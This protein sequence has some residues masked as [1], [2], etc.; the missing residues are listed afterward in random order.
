MKSMKP[1]QFKIATED[2]EL[3]LI[4]RLNYKTFVEEIPQH[5]ANPEG[6]L[7]DRFHEQ[8]TYVIALNDRQL[9]GMVCVRDQRPFSLDGKLEDL[10]K[11]LPRHQSLCE[12]RLLSVEPEYRRIGV[13]QGLL[14]KMGEYCESRGYDL[15]V[16]SGTVR[17]LGLYGH[18]GF[19]PFGPLVGEPGAQFQP[20]Y[21]TR[22][23]YEKL[24]V[25]LSEQGGR[26]SDVIKE[27]ILWNFLPGPVYVKPE[28]RRAVSQTP[29]S[30][31]SKQFLERF[32]RTRKLLC[33]LVNARSVEI[34]SGSG[35]LA[36]DVIG[37]QLS[38][39]G[40]SGLILSCGEF[41]NRLIDHAKRFGLSFSVLQKPWGEVFSSSE[42]AQAMT[43]SPAPNWL[44]T[45]HCETSS[46]ALMDLPMLVELSLQ[47]QVQLCLDCT[48]SLGIVPLDLSRVFLASS[49]SGKGLASLPGLCLVFYNHSVAPAPE[50]LPRVI[51]LGLYAAHDGVPFTISSNLVFGLETALESIHPARFEKIAGYSKVIRSR[52]KE[53]GFQLV[54][55]EDATSPGVITIALDRRS[56][57]E[58]VG[59]HLEQRGFLLSYRSHYLRERNWMQICLMGDLVEDSLEPLVE[60]LSDVCMRESHKAA[61]AS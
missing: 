44:W 25:S 49:V 19:V 57:S 56:D 11:W 48:S 26:E 18:L 23:A 47:N 54:G 46:G 50:R 3:E 1:L 51:D 2:W 40:K 30:H 8:N 34:F 60:T 42:I 43:A 53:R 29:I 31:R 5:S 35:T 55:S 21:L 14:M 33:Q 6:R 10:D 27:S 61:K 32:Q 17:Q 16:M 12:L 15:A 39:L 38:L 13:F 36:N 37:A 20:M 7:I 28:V 52:L 41:G 24:K 4:H 9:A 58:V 22:A 45:V 59:F